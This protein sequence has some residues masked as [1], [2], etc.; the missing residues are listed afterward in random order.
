MKALLEHNSRTGIDRGKTI[1]DQWVDEG[2]RVGNNRYIAG[3]QIKVTS[4]H[5]CGE[6]LCCVTEKRAFGRPVLPDV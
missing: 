2:Q 1:D 4:H 6:N 5:F 3:A